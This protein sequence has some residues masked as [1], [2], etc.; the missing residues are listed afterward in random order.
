M[1]ERRQLTDEHCDLWKRGCAL[2]QAMSEREYREGQSDRYYRF[3]DIDKALTWRL[4][5]PASESLFSA[6][7]DGPPERW[8][9][10]GQQAIEWPIAQ[11]WRKALIE[12]SGMTPRKFA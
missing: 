11:T 7:L 6:H 9:S 8:A 1:V 12:A 2:L 3:C 5:S 4:V 10:G